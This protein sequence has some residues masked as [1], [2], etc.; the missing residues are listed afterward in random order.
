MKDHQTLKSKGFSPRELATV[1]PEKR[2]EVII[3]LENQY[4][5]CTDK[6]GAKDS[7]AEVMTVKEEPVKNIFDADEKDDLSATGDSLI[8]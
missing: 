5:L 3:R 7:I 1:A 2:R 6:V 8:I 4:N